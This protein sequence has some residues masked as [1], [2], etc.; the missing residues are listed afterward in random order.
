MTVF[1]ALKEN[2]NLSQVLGVFS[3]E[4]S[5]IDCCLRQPT[6]THQNWQVDSCDSCWHNGHGL[7]VKV[8]K[9]AVQ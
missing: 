1:I 2:S 9:Y 4:I 3:N 8:V 6:F 5:A 7:Y